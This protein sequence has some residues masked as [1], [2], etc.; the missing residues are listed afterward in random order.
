MSDRRHFRKTFSELQHNS[1]NQNQ[2]DYRSEDRGQYHAPNRPYI[3]P[4]DPY[5]YVR[6][7][8]EVDGDEIGGARDSGVTHFQAPRPN[9]PRAHHHQPNINPKSNYFNPRGSGRPRQPRG[10]SH[11]NNSSSRNDYTNYKNTPTMNIMK[12]KSLTLAINKKNQSS[13]RTNNKNPEFSWFRITLCD[14]FNTEKSFLIN[15]LQSLC[16]NNQFNPIK[17][18]QHEKDSIFFI[19]GAGKAK[20]ILRCNNKVLLPCG[21]MLR[22]FVNHTSEPQSDAIDSNIENI[23]K[24]M[25]SQRYNSETKTID[26][27]SFYTDPLLSVENLFVSLN[28]PPVVNKIFDL[29]QLANIEVENLLLQNNNLTNLSAYANLGNIFPG[30][31]RLHIGDN[32][33]YDMNQFKHLRSLKDKII[34]LVLKGNPVVPSQIEPKEYIKQIRHYFSRVEV[35]DMFTHDSPVVFDLKIDDSSKNQ[36]LELNREYFIDDS[37]KIDVYSFLDQYFSIFDSENRD[38]LLMA[39]DEAAQLSISYFAPP[40]VNKSHLS[41]IIYVKHNRNLVDVNFNKKNS[42]IYTKRADILYRLSKFGKTKHDSESLSIQCF[43]VEDPYISVRIVGKFIECTPG[44]KTRSFQ[45]VFML[46]KITGATSEVTYKILNDLFCLTSVAPKVST[47][48]SDPTQTRMVQS[49]QKLTGLKFSWAKKCL[50][51][52]DWNVNEAMKVFEA[53]NNR[54]EFPEYA[55]VTN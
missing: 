39:Y 22:I 25:L 51:A 11:Y 1:T 31:K 55:F 34:E 42:K 12:N 2:S 38:S 28:S 5:K 21:Q 18:T 14:T 10:T 30:L 7:G 41:D 32:H 13:H 33:I 15:S 44:E 23:I 26:L 35:L 24:N 6:E 50:I 16:E 48:N 29:I 45:R 49:I 9:I 36:T 53:S 27:G 17:F 40:T 43:M 46:K 20:S 3:R 4:K 47:N 54:N 19:Q 52:S 8:L 37:V